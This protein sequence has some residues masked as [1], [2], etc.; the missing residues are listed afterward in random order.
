MLKSG[1]LETFAGARLLLSTVLVV[2]IIASALTIAYQAGQIGSLSSELADKSKTVELQAEDI[3][4]YMTA[5]AAHQLEIESKSAQ[6]DQ[7]NSHIGSLSGEIASKDEALEAKSEEA[8]LLAASLVS[9]EEQLDQLLAQAKALQTEIG[10]LQAKIR[11][12]EHR[13]SDLT[14]QMALT[15]QKLDSARVV[16]SH[17]G[18]GIDGSER[19]I[20]FPIEVEIINSGAGTT[21]V[22]VSNVQYEASFQGAVRTAAA[23]ASEYTGVPIADKDII[24]RFV[25]GD[26]DGGSGSAGLI[27]I[28]GPSAGA[29]IAGMIAAGLSDREVNPSVLVTGTIKADGTI[30]KI[31]GLE[32]KVEAAA[33]FGA[34]IILVP[35]SQEFHSDQIIVIGVSDMEEL[36]KY[37]VAKS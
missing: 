29:I 20:V 35:R 7:L 3:Q 24:V 12:N 33:G 19:G 37:L 13:I 26:Q 25:N 22:D 28:D 2:S 9:Q 8:R 14:A 11:S 15:Q 10:L 30:G 4:Q 18:L 32:S 16:V 17:Y 36:M 1:R 6:L 27:K 23:A 21:S 34:G 5:V 31:G